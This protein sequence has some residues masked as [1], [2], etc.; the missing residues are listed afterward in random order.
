M[1]FNLCQHEYGVNLRKQAKD[2]L[3]YSVSGRRKSMFFFL[4]LEDDGVMMNLVHLCSV[5]IIHKIMTWGKRDR[6]I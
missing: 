2:G 5:G 4:T 6:A 3:L 1:Y